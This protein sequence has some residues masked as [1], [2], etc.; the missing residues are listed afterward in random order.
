MKIVER[1]EVR[2]IL[3]PDAR[4]ANGKNVIPSLFY[5]EKKVKEAKDDQRVCKILQSDFL[6]LIS[7]AKQWY[8]KDTTKC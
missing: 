2:K 6:K 1:K 7:N 8:Q 3:S 5:V 4:Q